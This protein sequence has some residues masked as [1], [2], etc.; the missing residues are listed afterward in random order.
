MGIVVYTVIAWTLVSGPVAL[1]IGKAI[2]AGN[3]A[4][5]PSP[6]PTPLLA[7][8]ARLNAARGH[9]ALQVTRFAGCAVLGTVDLDGNPVAALLPAVI[10][11]ADGTAHSGIDVDVV[12]VPYRGAGARRVAD[13]LGDA[14]RLGERVD[15]CREVL[16]AADGTVQMSAVTVTV[17][18]DTSR[19]ASSVETSMDNTRL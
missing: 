4:T 17:C 12:C 14:E 3:V 15:V 6:E 9:G 18:G 2:A 8:E 11:G 7:P 10:G 5:E 13:L 19:R 16:H 1:V